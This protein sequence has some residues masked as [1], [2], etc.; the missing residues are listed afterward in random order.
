MRRVAP[1]VEVGRWAPRG[2]DA[3]DRSAC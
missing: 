1:A 3:F 2:R